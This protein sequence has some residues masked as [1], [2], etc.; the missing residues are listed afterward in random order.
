MNRDKYGTDQAPDC[1]PGTDVLVNLLDLRVAEDLEEAERYLNEVASMQMEFM[2]PP[3]SVATL[4]QIHRI[5]FGKIYGF[6]GEIRTLAISKGSTRFCS[7]E[8]I[9]KEISKELSRIANASWFDGYPRDLLVASIAESYGTLNVAHPFREGNG[10]TQ[11]ILYEWII[12]NAGYSIDWALAEREEWIDACIYSFHGD[13]EPLTK[14]FDRCIGK[15]IA[16]EI[17]F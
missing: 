9:E 7:P 16:E 13:D 3:Y 8:F 10:R 1:Y 17:G 14:I 4:K 5:L 2:E 12:F 15:T 11:R 6:A